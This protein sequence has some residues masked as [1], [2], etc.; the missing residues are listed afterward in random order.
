VE[1]TIEDDRGERDG[2]DRQPAAQ[3]LIDHV[4]RVRPPDEE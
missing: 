2:Q 3:V 4:I 1:Q